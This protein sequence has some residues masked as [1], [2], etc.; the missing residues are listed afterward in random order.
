M[1]LLYSFH[2]INILKGYYHWNLNLKDGTA[3]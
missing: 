2:K 3:V 1:Y